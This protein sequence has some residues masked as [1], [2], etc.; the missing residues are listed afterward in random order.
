MNMSFRL[1]PKLFLLLI[2]LISYIN[3]P[4]LLQLKIESSIPKINPSGLLSNFENSLKENYLSNTI[5]TLYLDS[6]SGSGNPI[7]SNQVLLNDESY[8]VQVI[9]TWSAWEA[10]E[11]SSYCGP[12]EDSP[13]IPSDG[14]TNGFV[15]IDAAYA[16]SLPSRRWN[17][18]DPKPPLYRDPNFQMS[19]NG[20]TTW[21]TPDPLGNSYNPNHSYMYRITGMGYPIKFRLTDDN[22]ASDNYGVFQI[23]IT[24]SYPFDLPYDY[25]NSSFHEE[26]RDKDQSGK[27]NSYFDHQFPTYWGTPTNSC[28]TCQPGD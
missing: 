9:G 27:I 24:K 4:E 8:L 2:I 15:G 6:R 26:I 12:A 13:Y 3:Q 23:L 17:C 11:W 10:W 5:D 25:S 21:F 20:G 19:I 18:T 28:D 16:F 14:V 7:T 22:W 1:I